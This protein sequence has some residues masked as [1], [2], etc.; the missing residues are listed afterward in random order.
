MSAI[1]IQQMADRVAAL[2]EE[3]L[4][5]RGTGLEAKLRKGRRLLPRKVRGA[6]D[7][8]VQAAKMAQNP[9]LLLQIDHEAVA[10]AYDICVRHLGAINQAERR[11]TAVVGVAGS[12]AFSV[13]V[14][15]VLLLAVLHWRG[16]V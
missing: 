3:R 1:T 13:L 15:G 10:S 6:A 2:M 14:V 5:L 4:R 11:M 9:K 16:F 7:I 12:I 8:L